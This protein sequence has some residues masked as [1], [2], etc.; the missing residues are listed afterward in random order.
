M[1][2]LLQDIFTHKKISLVVVELR[3]SYAKIGPFKAI[4]SICNQ[5]SL[6][7]PSNISSALVFALHTK[8]PEAF[9]GYSIYLVRVLW[10]KRIKVIHSAHY[11]QCM[12]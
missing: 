11:V 3:Q 8:M 5:R 7:Q 1:Q 6:I 2:P 9:Q 12:L 10:G 4:L